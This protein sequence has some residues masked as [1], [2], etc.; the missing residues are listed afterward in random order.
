MA[1]LAITG[2]FRA[3]HRGEATLP[4]VI[5]LPCNEVDVDRFYRNLFEEFGTYVGPGHR[6]EQDRRFFRL[7]L[8]GRPG[9]SSNEALG[10]WVRR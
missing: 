2:A 6:F 9:K 1:R 5:P 4:S 8:A 10:P 7:G 3:L